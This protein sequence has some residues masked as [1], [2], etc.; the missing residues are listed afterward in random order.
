MRYFCARND[1]DNYAIDYYESEACVKKK[2][3]IHCCG[4]HT[5][6]FS[7]EEEEV[8]GR[9]GIKLSPEDDTGRV[10]WLRCESEDERADWT[11]L[12]LNACQKSLPP[13]H[14]DPLVAT[15]FQATYRALR[16]RYGYS[17]WYRATYTETE[18]LARLCSDIADKEVL[19]AAF[20]LLPESAQRAATIRLV[21][22]N[23]DAAV[24]A[25]AG[26]A[27][28]A[29]L[30]ACGAQREALEAQVRA[31]RELPA[32]EASLAEQVTATT[33]DVMGPFLRIMKQRVCLTVL[34]SC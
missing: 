24:T 22:K 17:G 15:A 29:S 19:R 4:H 33:K 7:A 23:V 27:W 28:T 31:A 2:G 8:H 26:K 3:T 12:L 6:E 34:R 21:Q 10:W 30:A 25:A 5:E 20:S 13:V 9:H 1:S 14:P 32:L 18:H 16:W 11:K